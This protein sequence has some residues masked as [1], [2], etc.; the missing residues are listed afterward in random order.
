ML[1][2]HNTDDMLAKL[3][4]SLQSP[5]DFQ[6]QPFDQAMR[7]TSADVDDRGSCTFRRFP[8]SWHS[9][10]TAHE[11]PILKRLEASEWSTHAKPG[12]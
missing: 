8:A 5:D 11:L 12:V 1:A 6:E 2:R 4:H 7:E 9:F 3:V 10:L